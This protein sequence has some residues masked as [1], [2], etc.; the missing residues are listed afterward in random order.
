MD[1]LL[2]VLDYYNIGQAEKV[3]CPFHADKNPSMQVN[4][5]QGTWFCYGCQEG[6]D[7]YKF[8]KKMQAQMGNDNELKVIKIYS[9]IMSKKIK[10]DFKYKPVELKDA[11][12]YRQKLI[13]AKDHYNGLKTINWFSEEADDECVEYMLWR[14]FKK[15]TLNKAGAKYTYRDMYYPIIFPMLDNGKFKGW[16]CRSFDK[17]I[18]DER[19][20]LYNTGFRRNKTLVG[21][22]RNTEVVMIVEGYLDYLKAIQFGQKKVVALLGWKITENQVKKLKAEGVKIVISAL[23]NDKCGKDGTEYL[24]TFFEVVKFP[25]PNGIKDMGDMSKKAFKRSLIK[26]NNSLSEKEKE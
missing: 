8:H 15:G 14:G 6:G 17:Q 19:K 25:Y 20:Y 24:K 13:E 5:S 21:E 23:D 4:L 3:L 11:A 10:S 22:Y 9:K 18:S 16:V 12:Y 1:D 26:V 7:A 2:K